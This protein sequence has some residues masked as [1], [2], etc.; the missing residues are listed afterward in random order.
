MAEQNQMFSYQGAV[1]L[2]ERDAGGKPV[3]PEWVGDATVKVALATETAEHNESF[4][5]QR[6]PYAR[7]TTRKS[8]TV[9]LTLFEARSANLAVAL[10]ADQVVTVS[11]SSTGETFPAGLAVGDAVL[12]DRSFVSNLQITDSTG[13]P[14]TLTAGVHYEL[15]RPNAGLVRILALDGVTQPFRAAYSYQAVENLTLFT[16]TPPEKWLLLDG[17]NTLDDSPVLVDLFRVRFDPASELALHNEEFGSLELTGSALY[18]AALG[19]D[20]TLGGFGR[21]VRKAGVA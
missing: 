5:G 3:K 20:P 4:S 2:C 9:T 1:F 6:L 19:S 10:Y 18:D 15:E 11:G 14:V 21:V 12:L 16:R 17:V 13:S 8:A 7:M